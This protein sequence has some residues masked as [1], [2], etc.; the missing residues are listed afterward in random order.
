MKRVLELIQD[1]FTRLPE[2]AGL[3]DWVMLRAAHPDQAARVAETVKANERLR[4]ERSLET[5]LS[6][7]NA[8]TALRQCWALEAAGKADKA[9]LLE[10]LKEAA[11][12]GVPLPFDVK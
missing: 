11:R 12:A 7:L 5:K 4:L 10:P 8:V 9:A 3:W 6:P 1:E 2:R